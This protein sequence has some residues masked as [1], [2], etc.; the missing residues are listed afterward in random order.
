MSVAALSSP[1]TL[2]SNPLSASLKALLVPTDPSGDVAPAAIAVEEKIPALGNAL[3]GLASIP[4]A[5]CQPF[6]L[7]LP[8]FFGKP[9]TQVSLDLCH[10]PYRLFVRSLLLVALIVVFVQGMIALIRGA[11]VDAA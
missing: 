2:S 7:P 6:V 4:A 8:G 3:P 5:S 11:F 10:V 9:G 1:A